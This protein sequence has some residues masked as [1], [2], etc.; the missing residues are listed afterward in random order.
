MNADKM[1]DNRTTLD[2]LKELDEDYRRCYEQ[3]HKRLDEGTRDEEDRILAD[4]NFDARQLIRSAF[5]YIEGATFI[6]KIEASFN[7]E[8]K[9]IVLSPQ[10]HQLI[11][12]V[13][14]DL[15]DKGEI[16]QRPAKIPLS[17]NIKYAFSVFAQANGI[18]NNLDVSSEWWAK[19][20]ESI[21]VRDRLMHPRFPEDLDVSP[22]EVISIIAAKSGFDNALLALIK[23][24]KA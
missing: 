17:K 1:N 12:E 4:T 21:K 9:G 10:H 16:I 6:L 22:Q 18:E 3:I 7:S 5:A 15:N 20:K 13:D 19:L 24:S 2:L 8:E 23:T 14:F 11:F